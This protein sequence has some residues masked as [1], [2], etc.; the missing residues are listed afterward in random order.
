M[1]LDYYVPKYRFIKKL[2]F[3]SRCN[4]L[5]F[6]RRYFGTARV[7]S[8]LVPDDIGGLPSTHLAE[9]LASNKDVILYQAEIDNGKAFRCLRFE[10]LA[11]LTPCGLAYLAAHGIWSVI[12]LCTCDEAFCWLRKEYSTRNYF[13]IY[14]NRIE[15]NQPAIR[16]PF[17]WLGCGSWSA[18]SIVAHP[19]DRG[20]FGFQHI[21]TGS[22]HHLCC[23]WPMYGGVVARHRCQCF[24]PLW[25]RMFTDCGAF[26]RRLAM[27]AGSVD[28]WANFHLLHLLRN[29]HK[30]V[31]ARRSTP[32]TKYI[33]MAFIPAREVAIAKP[34]KM[35]AKVKMPVRATASKA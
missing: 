5:T 16:C 15:T 3:S 23:C 33:A 4:L 29:R 21:R 17:G 10:Y 26:C 11:L 25:N 13:R 12:T 27:K 28:F 30:A 32:A 14:S 31:P 1:S 9:H 6:A 24:G 2:V 19:F 34:L 22:L 35:L 8:N 7:G 20:A 18:D